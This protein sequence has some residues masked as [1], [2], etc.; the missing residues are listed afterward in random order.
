MAVVCTGAV[1]TSSWTAP[2][3]ASIFTGVYPDRHRVTAGLI[4]QMR[5][6]RVEAQSMRLRPIHSKLA[7]LTEQL[8]G[9]GLILGAI[10]FL[11]IPPALARHRQG[12][13]ASS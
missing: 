3:T 12:Q 10:L 5:Q 8:A 4:A 9:A 13:K 11:S 2:S 6:G 7:T 1:S